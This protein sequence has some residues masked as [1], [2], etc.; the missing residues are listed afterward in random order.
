M[1][2]II[3]ILAFLIFLIGCKTKQKTVY[4]KEYLTT[5]DTIYKDKLVIKTEKVTDTLIIEEPCDDKGQIKDFSRKIKTS[6]GFVY[7]YSKNGK[8]RAELELQGTEDVK[9]KEQKT[10]IVYKD[11]VK[12]VE[13][14]VTK[15]L[16]P[17][18]FVVLF[19]VSLFINFLYI[20][21]ALT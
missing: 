8:L 11:K 6:K 19:L 4:E 18:W 13:V 20:K 12:E 3:L 7:V 16:W 15:Y 5:I 2:K 14:I 1:K 17:V 21:K 9:E 10:K